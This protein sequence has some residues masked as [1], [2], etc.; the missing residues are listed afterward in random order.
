LRA[1]EFGL[2]T[3]PVNE[4][5]MF[6]KSLPLFSGVS[7]LEC[8]NILSN[9]RE[10]NFSRRQ[11]IFAEGDPLRQ[12]L[13]LVSGCVKQ[14]QF[15][16]DGSEVILRLAGPGEIIG[17][18]GLC[19]DVA[20]CST[21]QTMEASTVMVWSKASFESVLDRF[22]VLHRNVIRTLETRLQDMDQRF[23]EISTQRVAP[24]LSSQLVRLMSQVGKRINGHMEI[25]LSRSELAQLT[26][27]TLFTVSRLLSQ[28]EQL[29]IVDARRECVTVRDLPALVELSQ[30]EPT[31]ASFQ[32]LPSA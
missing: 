29:G 22:P 14:T 23:R 4:K 27:T 16:E 1:E 21:A 10:H 25:S 28:W 18:F 13:L 19:S 7:L 30:S 31:L 11:T 24:R 20:H 17:G 3:N 2:A 12:I 8:S 5:A 32:I 26:G 9:S 6:L 15:G